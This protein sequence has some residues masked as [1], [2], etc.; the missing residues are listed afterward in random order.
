MGTGIRWDFNFRIGWTDHAVFAQVLCVGEIQ[1][2]F[3][4]IY[5][6]ASCGRVME[7]KLDFAPFGE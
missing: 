4:F 1:S 5:F 2:Q 6:G 3:A 7:L